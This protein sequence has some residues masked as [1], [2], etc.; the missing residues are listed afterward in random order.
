MES[1]LVNPNLEA[2]VRYRGVRQRP[3]GKYAA[4]IRDPKVGARVWLGT[5]DSAIDAA[6]AYDKA[7]FEIRGRK[8]SL[9]F[10]LEIGNLTHE[11]NLGTK[12]ENSGGLKRKRDKVSSENDVNETT[13]LLAIGGPK[14]DPD[15]NVM[16]AVSGEDRKNDGDEHLDDG[17]GQSRLCIPLAQGLGDSN[18][19]K[20]RSPV[21]VSPMLESNNDNAPKETFSWTDQLVLVFCDILEK[22]HMMNGRNTPFKWTDLQSEFEEIAHCKLNS[23]NALKNKYDSMRGDYNVWTS[24]K[25]WEPD[26]GFNES[27]WKLDWW[28]QKLMEN[29]KVKRFHKKQPS[30]ELQEAW[31]RLFGNVAANG[32]DCA[33]GPIDSKTSIEVQHVNLEDKDVGNDEERKKDVSATAQSA[34][35]KRSQKMVKMITN[36][37][38]VKMTKS[39]RRGSTEGVICKDLTIQQNDNQPRASEIIE[40][41]TSSINQVGS[42]SIK[43]AIN[44]LNRM[45]DE[46]LMTTGSELWCFA[47]SFF[48][49][50]VR[51]ELFLNLPDDA[52]RLAWLQYKQN[53]AK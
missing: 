53:L 41:D 3:W 37:K 2:K 49:D 48:E 34:G 12:C 15:G 10:P 27:T 50:A 1:T 36:P 29:P 45:V 51:R 38:P 47:V 33:V 40:S 24:L 14:M 6:K 46:G 16:V 21:H 11:S 17:L 22:Y 28:E 43:S 20:S 32:V 7:A 25:T 5:F 39:K 52:G 31:F 9:N 44:E 26:L 13:T 30:L 19:R 4:E 23:E 42:C 8:A 18:S 35:F